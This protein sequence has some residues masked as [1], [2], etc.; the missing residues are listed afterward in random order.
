MSQWYNLVYI[1]DLILSLWFIYLIYFMIYLFPAFRSE[2]ISQ[3]SCSFEW[4][5]KKY[6]E[7]EREREGVR[8]GG[9]EGGGERERERERERESRETIV[10]I[11][12]HT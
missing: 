9:R 11:C 10:S 6:Y 5:D 3:L 1:S 12:H 2:L 4:W 7:G 8:E